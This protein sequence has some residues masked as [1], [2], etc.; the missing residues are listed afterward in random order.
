MK[1]TKAIYLQK[2]RLLLLTG[3]F[4]LMQGLASAAFAQAAPP[5]TMSAAEIKLALKKLKVVGSVLYVAAH[6][7]DENTRMITYMAN[8]RGVRTAYLSL[9]RGDGGQNLIGKE[10]RE[11]MG[12][13]RTQEL[14]AARR[15]DGGEQFFS[16]ANDFGYSKHPDETLTIWDKEKILADVVW[17]IRKFR[18]DVMIT[19]FSPFRD[20]KTHGHHT[21]SAKLALEAF[22]AAADPDRFPEQLEY[23]NTWQ[24]RRILWNTSWWF[25]RGQKNPDMSKYMS[26]DVG[27][28]NQLLGKSYGEIAAAS[29]SMHRS[30][31]FGAS[32]QRGREMEYFMHLAGDSA[33]T[34]VLEDIDLSWNRIP[35]SEKVAQLVE[36]AWQRFDMTAPEKSLPV[37]L[38][39]LR[40]LRAL[41]RDNH[42]LAYKE[43]QLQEIILSC[44]GIWLDANAETVSVTPGDSL[45]ITARIIKRA[46]VPV[47]LQHIDYTG[48]AA[49]EQ[50]SLM[51]F[52]K[53]IEITDSLKV[54]AGFPLSQPYW[55][56]ETP[57]KGQFIVT[58]QQLIGL[59][60]NPPAMQV[61]YRLQFNEAPDVPVEIATPVMYRWVDPAIGELYRP[62]AITPPVTA[63]L[64]E[65]VYIYASKQPQEVSVLLRSHTNNVEGTLAL[66]LPPG[67]QTTPESIKFS[68]AGTGQEKQVKFTVTPPEKASAGRLTAVPTAN[69][70]E[71]P[72]SLKVIDYPH[73]PVQTIFP[74]AEARIARLK[75]DTRRQLVGYIMG[76]GDAIPEAL[77]QIGYKVQLLEEGDF[78][79]ENL[80]RYDAIIAGVRA[81]NTNG[82]LKVHQPKLMEYVKNGGNFIIQY[83]TSFR[84]ATEDL[85]PYPLQ[86]S[87]DRVTVEEAPVKFLKPDHPVLNFPNRITQTDFDG[88]VQERGLYFPN[89][90]SEEYEPI[91][92]MNDP[93][94]DPKQGSLLTARYGKGT[95]VYTG[96]S[97]FREL[98]AGVP[99]AFRLFAN[100]VEFGNKPA[101]KVKNEGSMNK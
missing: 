61:K 96:L 44:A 46:K 84:L 73:I 7:D 19:R 86:L 91:L 39:A 89:E 15:T 81:Y 24:P 66:D 98:P 55:L 23:V 38:K 58:D 74:P 80:Q 97:F 62:L 101:V 18:P 99:G 31:G 65:Q 57:E 26:L 71:W 52:N 59:P 92:E 87:R 28:Y 72:Y 54:P 34:D 29:R 78:T 88:W 69:G 48:L 14:L 9:T 94:E 35:G 64:A 16:R 77:R 67:W 63:N 41:P 3:L 13:I 21:T 36:T 45:K 8:D 32:M 82:R 30:Q 83:N 1:R 68:M 75:I 47:V 40:E 100:L 60:E 11:Q 33:T 90:W 49:F 53:Q 25:F 6:P 93:G 85:G 70:R 20:G 17:A 56:R 50:D 4:L 37:L 43:Q 12:L 51:P 79:P 10:V 2:K 76:A 42:F 95:F 22:T 27:T 5:P